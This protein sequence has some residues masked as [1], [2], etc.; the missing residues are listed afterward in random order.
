MMRLLRKI[1]QQLILLL[2]IPNQILIYLIWKSKRFDLKESIVIFSE[3]RGGSTWLME[4]LSNIP[5]SCLNWEP[6]HVAKGVVPKKFRFG[7]R[8]FLPTRDKS[9]TYL[10]LFK[11]IISFSISTKW[12]RKY[13]SISKILSSKFVITKFTR[14]NLLVPYIIK[15]LKFDSH[16]QN[17]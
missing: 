4:I 11:R 3:A 1:K 17:P 8:P 6:L 5:N 14:A 15:N 10:N 2:D 16:F 7:S 12:S 13:L 9:E